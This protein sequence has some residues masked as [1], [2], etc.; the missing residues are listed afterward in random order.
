M[1]VII[2]L[3]FLAGE[4]AL[5]KFSPGWYWNHAPA[6]IRDFESVSLE[7]I[8]VLY[9]G[10]SV[11][12]SVY[13]KESDQTT[14]PELLR[15]RISPRKLS[16]VSHAAYDQSVYWEML[17]Y[18]EK[19]KNFPNTVIIPINLRSF[20]PRWQWR[21]EWQFDQEFWLLKYDRI[22]PVAALYRPLKT[23]KYFEKDSISNEDYLNTRV[24][25]G[26]KSQGTLA[27]FPEMLEGDG[28]EKSIR[29]MFV[30]TYLTDLGK[31]DRKIVA[32]QQIVDL[33]RRNNFKVIFYLTPIDYKS[34]ELYCGEDFENIVS[35][36]IKLITEAIQNRGATVVDLSRLFSSD[37]F[38]WR[39]E[40]II[41]EHLLFS[42][43]KLL[44][45]KIATEIL[46]NKNN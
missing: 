45:D 28:D 44:V 9:F 16:V 6:H 35:N 37:L 27:D 19:S 1:V 31:S 39:P 41:N 11:L 17:K 21:P 7:P 18:L 2:F 32:L 8:D 15:P 12:D 46:G 29:N 33:A 42:G 30:V 25:V 36:K 10:D 5:V 26:G 23:F 34:G 38:Y 20:S 14:I 24:V 22:L 40:K 43:R 13:S 3:I 4:M